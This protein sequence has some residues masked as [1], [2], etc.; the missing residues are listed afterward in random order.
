V[1]SGRVKRLRHEVEG[2]SIFPQGG[3]TLPHV[4]RDV[5]R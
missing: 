5:V 3:V 4:F 1:I 2:L